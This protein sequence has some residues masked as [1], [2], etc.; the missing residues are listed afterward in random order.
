MLLATMRSSMRG[1]M[2]ALSDQ[3]RGRRVTGE[4]VVTT[5]AATT[6]TLATTTGV[7]ELKDQLQE[8]LERGF[9]RP[10]VLSWGAPVLFVKKKDDSMRLFLLA[11]D[12]AWME[13]RS[14][15]DQEIKANMVFMAQTE[16]VLSDSEASSS[17]A[18]DKIFETVHMIMPSKDE[19]YN[20]RKGIGFENPS[21]FCKA[22]DL[23]PTLYDE[24]IINLG[25]TPMFLTHSDKALEIEK[26]KRARENKIEFAYDYG[27][28]NATDV[29]SM[30]SGMIA[31]IKVEEEIIRDLERL[32]I[33]LY[34][35]G[36]HGYWASLRVEIKEA[37][38]EDSEIWTIV[39]NLDEQTKFCLD[40]DNVLWQVIEFGDSYK[41]P[42]NADLADS[43]TGRTITPTIED[44][45][46]KNNVKART[47]LL[48]SLPDEHQLRFS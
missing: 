45:Q 2:M 5:T 39:E 26:F 21:Y 14:D 32:D 19:M 10:S 1:M 23:R 15:S 34:V 48:L 42:A 36:Q 27:N 44:M 24:R 25:Y 6:T 18:D 16:K 11:E 30:K 4:V 47:T 12:H 29:L 41:V 9:I 20:G 7:P 17:S 33:E 13:S 40:E 37:Q 38:K 3:T 22:K 43:R 35:H 46:K 31:S 28:L 8:L